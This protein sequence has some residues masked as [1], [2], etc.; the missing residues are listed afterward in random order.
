M[1]KIL[2]LCMLI[3][4]LSSCSVSHWKQGPRPNMDF[5]EN[6]LRTLGIKVENLPGLYVSFLQPATF[7]KDSR[8]SQEQKVEGG[9]L[10]VEN[11]I[12]GKSL[13]QP[14]KVPVRYYDGP[15]KGKIAKFKNG[16]IITDDFLAQI[17]SA[18][19]GEGDVYLKEVQ[20]ALKSDTLS[21]VFTYTRIPVIQ[22]SYY[23]SN[24]TSSSQT[25]FTPFSQRR[26]QTQSKRGA[27]TPS[28]YRYGIQLLVFDTEM[29]LDSEFKVEPGTNLVFFQENGIR[30]YVTQGQSGSFWFIADGSKFLYI[31]RFYKVET[32]N[33]QKTQ[34]EAISEKIGQ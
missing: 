29:Q 7:Y 14:Q 21:D 19:P 5:T 13:Y 27:K 15:E 8:T 33:N 17:V 30:Y 9:V 6:T 23:G 26:Q 2:I 28:D 16:Q 31:D 25:G 24:S 11:L 4:L 20:I 18:T 32:T 1:K 34:S 10:Y 12:T 22:D 3:V